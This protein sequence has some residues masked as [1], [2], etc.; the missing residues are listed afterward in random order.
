MTALTYVFTVR[1]STQNG[2]RVTG[3]APIFSTFALLSTN[4]AVTNPAI[5]EI[6]NGAY[7]FSYDAAANGEV[8][9][10]VDAGSTLSYPSDRYIDG[11]CTF[12]LQLQPADIATIVADVVA[13]I[14]SGGGGSGLSGGQVNSAVWDQT[15]GIEVGLTPRQALRLATAAAAGALTGAGT[16][17]IVIDGAGIDTTRISATVDVNGNRSAVTLNPGS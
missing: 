8:A 9:W 11:T 12:A 7:K 10:Q 16:G 13:D 15:N 3:L 14:G 1:D 6:G 5:T 4:A 2:L 17:T